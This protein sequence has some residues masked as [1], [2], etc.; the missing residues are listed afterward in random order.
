MDQQRVVGALE[1]GE[2]VRDLDAAEA[3]LGRDAAAVGILMK[4]DPARVERAR[5]DGEPDRAGDIVGDEVFVLADRAAAVAVGPIAE[6]ALLLA[7]RQTVAA[8]RIEDVCAQ[9]VWDSEG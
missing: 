4:V 2:A 1:E 6:I 3:V 5:L 9:S 8:D 7:V